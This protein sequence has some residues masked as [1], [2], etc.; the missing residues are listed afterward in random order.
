MIFNFIKN[1]INMIYKCVVKN[2][3]NNL[4]TNN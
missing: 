1:L 3:W 4:K 2:L